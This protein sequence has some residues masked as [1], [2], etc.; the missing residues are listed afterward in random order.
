MPVP[1]L[2]LS[3]FLLTMLP[4]KALAGQPYIEDMTWMEVRD[5]M[6]NGATSVIIPTGGVEQ[7]GPHMIT[8]KHNHIVRFTA[9]E[10]ASQIDGMLV[11]PVITYVPEGRISPP[12]GHMKFPGTMSVEKATFKALLTD[13]AASLK[14]HGFKRIYFIGDHG[15]SQSLQQEV[16]AT[17]TD[18]W[19]SGGV[20]VIHVSDYY[21]RN[22]QAEYAEQMAAGGPNPAG[23][24][25]LIDTS[26]L[27]AIHA[28]GV[29]QNLLAR[30]SEDDFERTGANGDS[31]AASA[32]HGRRFLSLKV[33]AAVKQIKAK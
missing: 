27:M 28:S 20:Q 1:K 19:A 18:R 13:A 31:K 4:A 30:N 25:A 11:A 9:G 8:G 6:Q 3:F 33:N 17:L 2:K 14:Q 12:E 22:G 15:G 26:E 5:A 7:N 23:H 16:A 21:A 29:R 10:I 32:A 24:A